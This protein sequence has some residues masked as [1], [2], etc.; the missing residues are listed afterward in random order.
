MS[1]VP[2]RA[3]TKSFAPGGWRSMT[4]WPTAATSEVAPGRI[5]AISSD[6][7]SAVSV[8]TAP[9]IAARTSGWTALF[10]GPRCGRRARRRGHLRILHR[11]RDIRMSGRSGCP[12][13]RYASGHARPRTRRQPARPRSH[14][15][16]RPAGGALRLHR[17][18]RLGRG[19]R[20]R[21]RGG[22]RPGPADPAVPQRRVRRPDRDDDPGFGGRGARRVR[23]DRP[24][25]PRPSGRRAR[26][27]ARLRRTRAAVRPVDAV[28]PLDGG[29]RRGGAGRRSAG[30]SCT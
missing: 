14:R 11:H 10:A 28:Q 22:L 29:G 1:F 13:V 17:G 4:T 30:S 6:T 19:H 18:R 7:P 21:Q 25:P 2:K 23:P 5:P 15:P 26:R 12:S 8:A 16:R 27:G 24:A 20:R 9:A 3:T